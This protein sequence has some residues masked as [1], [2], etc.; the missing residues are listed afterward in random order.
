MAHLM[1]PSA[2]CKGRAATEDGSKL[3][4]F[5]YLLSGNLYRLADLTKLRLRQHRIKE[6]RRKKEESYVISDRSINGGGEGNSINIKKGCNKNKIKIF[7]LETN[8]NLKVIYLL[9]KLKYSFKLKYQQ[10]PHNHTHDQA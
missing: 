1:Q 7:S 9:Q 2:V 4:C 5:L 3:N 10:I 8:A 6:A